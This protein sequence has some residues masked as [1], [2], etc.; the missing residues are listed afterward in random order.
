MSRCDRG[1][2]WASGGPIGGGLATGTGRPRLG[3]RL[4]GWK[5]PPRLRALEGHGAVVAL[6][7]LV[8]GL[9]GVLG[10]EAIDGVGAD[11]AGELHVAFDGEGLGG[12]E[13]TGDGVGEV[14]ELEFAPA[15]VIAEVVAVGLVRGGADEAPEGAAV[16]VV[17]AD[18]AAFP[19][20]GGIGVRF[21]CGG[22]GFVEVGLIGEG[23]AGREEGDEEEREEERA[24]GEVTGQC[25]LP[26]HGRDARAPLLEDAAGDEVVEAA[27][28]VG[29]AVGDGLGIG[30]AIGGVDAVAGVGLAEAFEGGV[31]VVEEFDEDLLEF[32]GLGGGGEEGPDPAVVGGEA[33][34][35]GFGGGV[36]DAEFV[37]GPEFG[38][39]GLVLGDVE[40]GVAAVGGI[41]HGLEEGFA[42]EGVGGLDN[43]ADA[44]EVGEG[45]ELGVAEELEVPGLDG[46]AFHPGF[47]VGPGVGLG[48]LGDGGVELRAFLAGG[49]FLHPLLKGGGGDVGDAVGLGGVEAFGEHG[50]EGVLVGGIHGIGTADHHDKVDGEAD[51]LQAGDEFVDVIGIGAGEAGDLG[52][53][54]FDAGEVEEALHFGHD[55]EGAIGLAGEASVFVGDETSDEFDVG[56][57]DPEFD[58]GA[59]SDVG[60]HGGLVDRNWSV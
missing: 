7:G 53:G 3:S 27:G 1:T 55:G 8:G 20:A 48:E 54:D 24:H 6:V 32:S 33:S 18:P 5:P 28:G 46:G 52:T 37:V 4:G 36:E 29:E 43:F 50:D 19:G 15:G 26:C 21:G 14:A 51:V 13:G 12:S 45:L 30:A 47:L 11:E 2:T 16:A 10:D 31:F 25:W 60:R 44:A 59:Q 40:G 57:D 41:D 58:V 34:A 56:G 38:D 17:F 22:D 42:E 23:G 9:E 39:E 49:A 35:G